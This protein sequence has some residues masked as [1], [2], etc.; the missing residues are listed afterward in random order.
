M[1]ELGGYRCG[2]VTPSSSC[3]SCLFSL[4]LSSSLPEPRVSPAPPHRTAPYQWS[5][6]APSSSCHAL[7]PGSAAA[8]SSCHLSPLALRSEGKARNSTAAPTAR[9][10]QI[11]F[12]LLSVSFRRPWI[13]ACWA[14]VRRAARRRL[15]PTIIPGPWPGCPTTLLSLE[16]KREK[17]VAAPPTNNDAPPTPLPPA[18]HQTR[19]RV[20]CCVEVRFQCEAKSTIG[21]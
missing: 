21:R 9:R 19:A 3:V 8:L 11:F 4:S 13:A 20:G 17:K 6:S 2:D 12:F 15:L 16:R 7:A 10:P 1:D 18:P 5:S 14:D